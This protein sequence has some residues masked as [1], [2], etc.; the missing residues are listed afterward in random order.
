MR[1]GNKTVVCSIWP[2]KEMPYLAEECY[3]DEYGI[4]H[5]KGEIERVEL[6]TN[7]LA[8]INRTIPMALFESSITF[9]TDKAR[10]H[11]KTLNDIK[12]QEEFM[13]DII[14]LLNHKQGREVRELYS[15]LSDKAK[16][17]FIDSAINEGIYI[18]YE[19]FDNKFCLRDNII[20]VYEKYPDIM[21]PWE[22]FIPKPKWGRDVYVGA[23]Y[24]G[25][26][27]IMM[28]KQ[29]GERG[30]S[31]RSAGSINDE[32][33][34]EKSNSNKIGKHWASDNAVRFGE[35][36]S[37]NLLII[38][39]ED[40]LALIN[41]LYRSSIS[42]RKF[43][44]ESIVTGEPMEVPNS[45]T[46]RAAE[47]LQVYLKSLGIKIETIMTE[48][49]FIGEPEHSN[50]VIG[51]TIKNRVIFC[52]MNEMYYL[53]KLSKLYKKYIHSR[54]EKVDDVEE[55][56]DWMMDNLTFKKKFLSEAII[57]LFKNNIEAFD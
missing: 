31:A 45:F 40:D 43:L 42:G 49:E 21:K 48:D 52:T 14:E 13:L 56:W 7:P 5:P 28:L 22:I 25:Y 50:E 53:K 17:K 54:K 47:I 20:K 18:R 38:L 10:K 36:E 8:I 34:P 57:D 33:L 19:A 12:E 26:Q 6:I 41:A 27:Y 3:K 55:A 11:M 9:I 2:D 4:V 23:D 15:K 51:F 39:N 32:S 30:F 29:S 46:N 35:Y 24:I 16:R 37:L 1:S 44:Y